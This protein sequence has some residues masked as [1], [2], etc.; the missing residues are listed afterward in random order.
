MPAKKRSPRCTGCGKYLRQRG[1]GCWV[2]EW[3]E[4]TFPN[5][6]ETDC[7]VQISMLDIVAADGA[8]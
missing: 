4:C 3:W 8:A 7:P 1:C 5:H 2:C 6:T